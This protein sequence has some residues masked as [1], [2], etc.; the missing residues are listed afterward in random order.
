MGLDVVVACYIDPRDRSR[1]GERLGRA[2]PNP[3]GL[4]PGSRG[5]ILQMDDPAPRRMRHGISAPGR[6]ELVDQPADMEFG[7]VG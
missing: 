6:V 3:T 1:V 7:G 4:A 5:L 2:T